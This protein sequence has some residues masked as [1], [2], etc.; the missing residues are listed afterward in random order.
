M[1]ISHAKDA[2]LYNKY[3]SYINID[4]NDNK[5]ICFRLG[6]NN[7]CVCGHG[8]SKHYLILCG[9]KFKSNCKKCEGKKYKYIP[10][11]P[12]ETNEYTK[13][14]LLD[15][16]YD[17][18]KAG[19]KCGHNWTKHNFINDGICEECNCECFESNFCC[20]V[21]GNSWENHITLI[22]NEKHRKNNGESIGKDYK[23]FT[24]EQIENLLK[25]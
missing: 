25:D 19:C 8:F 23:P 1:Q 2:I 6:K 20:G 12:E 3:V 15:F 7:M 11:V 21:C 14:Y 10:V 18:W 17:D 13:A 22:Q 5:D 9:E 24:Q 16:K 4:R